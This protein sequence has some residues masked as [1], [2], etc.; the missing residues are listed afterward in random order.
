MKCTK[1][2]KKKSTVNSRPENAVSLIKNLQGGLR[3]RLH[4]D[5]GERDCNTGQKKVHKQQ[6]RDKKEWNTREGGL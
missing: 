5:D 3:I 6:H 2:K 1:K 4:T